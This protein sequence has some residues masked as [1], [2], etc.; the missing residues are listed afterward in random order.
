[1]RKYTKLAIA[2]LLIAGTIAVALPAPKAK[3]A[4]APAPDPLRSV[5]IVRVCGDAYG[6][7]ITT[8]SGT[9]TVGA[10]TEIPKD[11]LDAVVEY[12]EKIDRLVDVDIIDPKFC[13][14]SV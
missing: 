1:M 2:A 3:P 7:V 10:K 9:Y 12:A 6:Y 8:D 11:V 13:G 14:T 4:P 5:T